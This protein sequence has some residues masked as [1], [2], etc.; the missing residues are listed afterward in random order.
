MNY[1][2]S[3]YTLLPFLEQTFTA[4]KDGDEQTFC[5][6]FAGTG[7]VGRHFKRLG[8]RIIAN[9]L[10]YYAYVINKAFIE[11]DETP[12]FL[13]LREQY[14]ERMAFHRS[15]FG[16]S[17]D[18]VLGFVNA[19]PPVEGFIFENYGPKGSRQYYTAE[20]AGK[21]DGVRLAIERWRSDG[22]ITEQEYFYILT[23]LLE[24][25]DKVANTA[26]VY[27]AFLKRYKES[28]LKPL[29]LRRLDVTN[30]GSGSRVH[31]EDANELIK[32]IESD[33]LYLDPPYNHRQYGANY[34]VLETIARYD[35]PQ[36]QGISGMRDYI[37]S[38]YCKPREVLAA[39]EHLV[40]SARTRHILVSYNDEGLMSIEEV[41]NVLAL[42]G[43]PRTFQ[44]AY[45]RYKADNGRLYKRE[46]TVEYVHYVRVVR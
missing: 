19:L 26:S 7:A 1:I 45:S 13:C 11:I 3:R 38:R 27:G 30:Q 4:V 32:R 43:E 24:A 15:L 33:V 12:S 6:I 2:G 42:R 20:N 22:V 35:S 21:A 18:E 14:A 44:T 28:A 16:D 46:S 31:N 37:R 23:S 41:L 34:H 25:I 10:Q 5:D 17:I 39:F 8:L 36:V 29:Y 9:D 40:R